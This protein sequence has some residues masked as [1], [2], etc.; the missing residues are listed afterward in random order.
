M[1]HNLG[2]QISTQ[3][4]SK[5]R[6]N[7]LEDVL[8]TPTELFGKL[9]ESFRDGISNFG[10]GEACKNFL[11]EFIVKKWNWNQTPNSS[12]VIEEIVQ[13]TLIKIYQAAVKGSIESPVKVWSWT[14]TTSLR[15]II[16]YNRLNNRFINCLPMETME[17]FQEQNCS[18]TPIFREEF[19]LQYESFIKSNLSDKKL[20]EKIH[21]IAIMY[22]IQ[23][24]DSMEIAEVL[25]LDR[26][27]DVQ[28]KLKK[29][30]NVSEAFLRA[31]KIS[32]TIKS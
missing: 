1:R 26:K 21:S 18:L 25:G 14:R 15:L 30:K 31:M 8:S 3:F 29:I 5:K 24:Y 20:K 4:Q 28:R 23:D 27:N 6:T 12:D 19:Y 9:Y 22:M 16:D 32:Y 17:S 13:Q 7:Q 11:Q 10:L 2:S